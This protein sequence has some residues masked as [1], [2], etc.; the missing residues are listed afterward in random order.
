MCVLFKRTQCSLAFFY[1]LCKR[2][3]VLLKESAC[4]FQKNAKERNVPLGF[5]S[6]KKFKKNVAFFK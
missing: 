6:C 2:K 1:V 3:H 4:S 5:I